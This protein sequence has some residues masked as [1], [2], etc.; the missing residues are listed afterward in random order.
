MNSSGLGN[1]EIARRLR[2]KGRS[3]TPSYLDRRLIDAPGCRVVSYRQTIWARHE[4][5]PDSALEEDGF[6]IPVPL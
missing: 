5:A 4:F 1:K 3:D 6:E 2:N